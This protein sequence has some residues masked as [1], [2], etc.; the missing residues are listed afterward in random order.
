MSAT[1]LLQYQFK[2]SNSSTT[3]FTVNSNSTVLKKYLQYCKFKSYRENIHTHH[4]YCIHDAVHTC[5][6]P[7][8]FLP[9]LLPPVSAKPV[10]SPDPQLQKWIFLQ[11]FSIKSTAKISHFASRLIVVYS[12]KSLLTKL[13]TT[14]ALYNDHKNC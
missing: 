8:N 2:Q 14:T 10:Q 3:C 13:S 7:S 12:N 6:N 1:N 4:L 11:C 5:S 9:F